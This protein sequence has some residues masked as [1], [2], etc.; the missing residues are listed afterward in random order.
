MRILLLFTILFISPL[1]YAGGQAGNGGIGI[2]IND[3]LKMLELVEYG[4]EDNPYFDMNMPPDPLVL[5][6]IQ[7]HFK[8]SNL[9]NIPFDKLSRKITE[10]MKRDHKLGFLL[11]S[12]LCEYDWRLIATELRITGDDFSPIK[13][14]KLVQIATRQGA[15]IL[16]DRNLWNKMDGDQKIVLLVHE[17]AYAAGR[18]HDDNG[19]S[20]VDARS[21]TGFLFTK[22]FAITGFEKFQ[23][24]SYDIQNV[25]VDRF[26]L[27]K[28]T[29][30]FLL[31]SIVVNFGEDAVWSGQGGNYGSREFN[32]TDGARYKNGRF[33]ANL[34]FLKG[35]CDEYI[36][37]KNDPVTRDDFRSTGDRKV[38]V[39]QFSFKPQRYSYTDKNGVE[40][41]A[42]YL[43]PLK[44]TLMP[45]AEINSIKLLKRPFQ[46]VADCENEFSIATQAVSSKIVNYFGM[47]RN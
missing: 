18:M 23:S 9:S 44:E 40:Q 41:M 24:Q 27:K 37:F 42:V 36:R 8:D 2:Y 14:G 28:G 43:Y 34:S 6:K 15:T 1:A 25:G 32:S 35:M 29:L 11:L 10:V 46:N 33:E 47:R 7:N 45:V 17:G 38:A 30:G 16:I 19:Q 39:Y 21:L 31:P 13:E 5:E 22:K 12:A 20:A 26:F 3:N 4:I